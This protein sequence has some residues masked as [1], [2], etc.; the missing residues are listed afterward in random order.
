MTDAPAVYFVVPTGID[1]P[2]RPSGGNYYDRRMSAGLRA[3]GWTVVE[4]PLD[5]AA[6]RATG[7]PPG[8]LAA[9]PP[10]A[11]HRAAGA[12]SDMAD[13]ALVVVDGL[14]TLSPNIVS[15]LFVEARP[16]RLRVVL[17]VHMLPP[18]HG[19]GALHERERDALHRA[20]AVVTTSVWARDQVAARY[21]VPGEK[22]F[23]VPPGTDPAPLAA[24]AGVDGG[25]GS[26][27][28]LL[29]VAAVLPA[30]G[31]DVLLTALAILRDLDWSCTFVGTRDLDPDFSAVLQRQAES[32]GIGDRVVFTG[33]LGRDGLAREYTRADVL[34][35][36]SRNES[37]GM[38]V[39]EALARGLPVIASHVGGVPEALGHGA[40]GALPGLLVPEE[41]PEAL[42]YAL[43]RW[44]GDAALRGTLRAAALNR[45]A[46]LAGWDG[47]AARLSYVLAGAAG[48]GDPASA[49]PTPPPSG[50]A[51]SACPSRRRA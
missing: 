49:V 25:G 11:A 38:V 19:A 42:A 46:S 10:V 21:G 20:G 50:T 13:G 43:R 4:V 1:N 5:T 18:V 34:L 12:L 7:P 17:L 32:S 24:G 22:V 6:G 16:D 14:I 41:S 37:Y 3:L 29:C 35:L 31:H 23:V 27:G 28:S 40:D 8:H 51:A 45:R 26:G 47:A 30:K 39:T 44:L 48:I 2:A 36:P 15:S 9:M 33:P